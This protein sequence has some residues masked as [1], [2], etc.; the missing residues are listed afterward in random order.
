MNN[1][2]QSLAPK[3][4]KIEVLSLRQ[5]RPQLEDGAVEA[6]ANNCHELKD[7]DLSRSFRL[8]DR[9][10]YALADGCPHLTR[11]NISGCSNFSD[12]ALVHLTACCNELKYLN[13]CGCV[14]AVSDRAL[15]VIIFF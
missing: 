3:F 10:L 12:S 14:R 4:T 1:L 2:V 13:L 8:S 11:L 9:S 6:V 7:L 15:Q 5:N